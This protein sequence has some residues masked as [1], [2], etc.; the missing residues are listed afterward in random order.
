MHL[1]KNQD[2]CEE[3]SNFIIPQ[4]SCSSVLTRLQDVRQPYDRSR[5][6]F[7]ENKTTC[8]TVHAIKESENLANWQNRLLW[9]YSEDKC[10]WVNQINTFL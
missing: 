7:A 8:Y 1:A 5:G 4:T 6:A 3:W 9:L 10:D 2:L